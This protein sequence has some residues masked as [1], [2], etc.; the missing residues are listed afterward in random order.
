[1][2]ISRIRKESR[3]RREGGRVPA[4]LDRG[5]LT[6]QAP[7]PERSV[8]FIAG[9]SSAGSLDRKIAQSRLSQETTKPGWLARL[10][11]CGTGSFGLFRSPTQNVRIQN[12]K[13]WMSNPA[14]QN[15]ANFASISATSNP[16]MRIFSRIQWAAITC[17]KSRLAPRGHR[18]APRENYYITIARFSSSCIR[19]GIAHPAIST[20]PAASSAALG[21]T[22]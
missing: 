18:P 10:F 15:L 17:A 22:P 3:F 7:R 9:V 4:S 21:D 19:T 12:V 11:Y 13:I 2:Q 8:C 1:V 14:S 20:R 6:G 5:G 16:P